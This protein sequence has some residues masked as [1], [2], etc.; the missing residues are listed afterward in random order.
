MHHT[1]LTSPRLSYA[2]FA[3]E[4]VDDLL[5][6][7]RDPDLRRFLLDGQLVSL[8]WCLEEIAQSARLFE[9]RGVGQWLV[10]ERSR[11]EL[12]VGFCGFRVFPEVEPEPELLYALLPGFWGRGYATE[13]AR[14]LLAFA[15]AQAGFGRVLSAV[16]APNAASIRVLEKLGFRARGS[17]P[18]EFGRILLFEHLP[19]AP[20]GC[21]RGASEAGP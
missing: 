17:V 15:R 21:A 11:P 19:E 5:A 9:A 3:P 6:L 2:P 7:A 1:P 12:P 18:G 14:A 10:A 4:Q 8:G 13:A 16:D 20:A